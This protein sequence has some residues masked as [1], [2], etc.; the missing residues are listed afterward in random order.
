M[1]NLGEPSISGYEEPDKPKSYGEMARA[2]GISGIPEGKWL[3]LDDVKFDGPITHEYQIFASEG[4][5]STGRLEQVGKYDC[6]GGVIAFV[7]SEG[8]FRAGRDNEE[9]RKILDEAGYRQGSIGGVPGGD[10]DF[11]VDETI[12]KEWDEIMAES[13]SE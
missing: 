12:K 5:E 10:G 1:A 3:N 4:A 13:D 9:A 7:D 8:H 2:R 11:P 6:R